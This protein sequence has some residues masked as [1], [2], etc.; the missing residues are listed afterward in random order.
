MWC[1]DWGLSALCLWMWN[2]VKGI[3]HAR[4]STN[5]PSSTFLFPPYTHKPLFRQRSSH[6]ALKNT[7]VMMTLLVYTAQN[8]SRNAGSPILLR[9]R[10]VFRAE[11]Q[12]PP[13]FICIIYTEQCSRIKVQLY[14]GGNTYTF[15]HVY[16]EVHKGISL[17]SCCILWYRFIKIHTECCR[18]SSV[19]QKTETEYM[20]WTFKFKYLILH[21]STGWQHHF[22]T[23]MVGKWLRK[24]ITDDRSIQSGSRI[25]PSNSHWWSEAI[26]VIFGTAVQK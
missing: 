10:F 7:Y 1:A 22:K 26:K 6:I 19:G 15:T 2:P 13:F 18:Y 3:T 17:Y 25:V 12:C 21:W 11:Q 5:R 24:Q 16:Q 14:K 4:H 23:N 9:H 8:M 20:K